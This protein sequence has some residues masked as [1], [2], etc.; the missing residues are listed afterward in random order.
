MV[1][2][3]KDIC[4][5]VEESSH[6]CIG[7][8]YARK[9]TPI[10]YLKIAMAK[11]WKKEDLKVIKIKPNMFQIFFNTTDEVEK[12]IKNGPWCLDNNLIAL[13]CWKPQTEAKDESF[14]SV[15]F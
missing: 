7:T 9:E 5:G 2:S 4:K 6:S 1:V 13:K 15:K 12:V 10:K 3:K 11:G 8:I 14:H